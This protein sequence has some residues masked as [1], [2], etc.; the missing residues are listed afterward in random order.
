MPAQP[1][2]LAIPILP[3]CQYI[4][5]NS[6]AESKRLF[7]QKHKAQRS[8]ASCEAGC[9]HVRH[10][11]M[12]CKRQWSRLMASAGGKDGGGG[13]VQPQGAIGAA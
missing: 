8:R 5:L 10:H 3:R 2:L 1:G 4:I 6:T 7:S 13:V 11:G 9:T 12:S